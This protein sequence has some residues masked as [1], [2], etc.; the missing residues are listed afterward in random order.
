MLRKESRQRSLTGLYHLCSRPFSAI[1]QH[2]FPVCCIQSVLVHCRSDFH[3]LVPQLTSFRP[4]ASCYTIPRVQQHIP[5]RP[6][7]PKYSDEQAAFV[8][9]QRIDLGRSWEEV[10]NAFNRQYPRDAVRGRGGLQCKFYRILTAYGV[11]NVR[12]QARQRHR[13]GGA[14]A[15]GL[16]DR[17]DVRYVSLR[18]SVGG[19]LSSTSAH[20]PLSSSR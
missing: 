10:V 9:Y 18:P 15:F 13:T 7:R 8:W 19:A 6:H 17:T 3:R 20:D 14:G 2:H 4:S 11:R 5:T 12:E 16:I 1:Q